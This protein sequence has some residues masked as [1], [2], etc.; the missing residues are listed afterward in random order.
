M[1]QPACLIHS[2]PSSTMRP[3]LRDDLIGAND[4]VAVA[5]SGGS[6]W[7]ALVRLLVELARD[8]AWTVAGLVHVNQGLRDAAAADEAFVRDLA[9]SLSLPIEVAHVD[10]GAAARAA[11]RS[12]EAT[13]R[14]ARYACFED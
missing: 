3:V 9:A 13:G 4:R 7:V 12:I 8:G 14:D 11:R 6:E 10:V 2:L 1:R 5:V